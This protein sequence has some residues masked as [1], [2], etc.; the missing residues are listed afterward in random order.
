M[1]LLV[2]NSSVRYCR[3][4]RLAL[5]YRAR[6]CLERNLTA[7]ARDTFFPASNYPVEEVPGT[8][9]DKIAANLIR[10]AT[11]RV[12]NSFSDAERTTILHSESKP[13]LAQANRRVQ[14]ADP[15][16]ASNCFV[17]T[18]FLKRTVTGAA[19][20]VLKVITFILWQDRESTW[21]SLRL[22]LLA[23]CPSDPPSRKGSA[24]G[25]SS[26]AASSGSG[27]CVETILS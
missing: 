7:R 12:S 17:V 27:S 4:M 3:P 26:S 2:C 14:I 15:P 6:S 8:T 11:K 5:A 16:A 10:Q 19:R 24:D 22:R 21:R 18:E 25:S 20:P 13:I 9:A 1:P 23:N